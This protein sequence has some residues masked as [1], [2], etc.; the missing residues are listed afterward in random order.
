MNDGDRQFSHRILTFS[1]SVQSVQTFSDRISF[2][3]GGLLPQG[4]QQTGLFW[5]SNPLEAIAIRLEAI[6]LR[7]D[8]IALWKEAIAL[9]VEAIDIKLE[10]IAL[11]GLSRKAKPC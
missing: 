1:Q 7:V 9:R 3:G 6:A 10:A 8:A 11:A 4:E 5:G 2:C